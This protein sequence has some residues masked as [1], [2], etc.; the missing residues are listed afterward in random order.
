MQIALCTHTQDPVILSACSLPGLII[1]LCSRNSH[2]C[3]H[4]KVTLSMHT[5]HAM[6]QV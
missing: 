5:A 3:V 6:V 1:L 4:E 2:V